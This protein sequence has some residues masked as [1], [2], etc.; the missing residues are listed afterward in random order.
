MSIELHYAILTV[1]QDITFEILNAGAGERKT[2]Q[3][4]PLQNL[5]IIITIFNVGP[6]AEKFRNS[7]NYYR[8]WTH[9]CSKSEELTKICMMTKRV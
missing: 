7:I 2:S 5:I 8:T 6:Y 9:A 3:S 4:L 1:K